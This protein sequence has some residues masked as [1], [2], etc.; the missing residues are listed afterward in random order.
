MALLRK[1]FIKEGKLR[2]GW[3]VTLYLIVY[4]TSMVLISA[5]LL[6]PYIH[7]LIMTKGAPPGG[8]GII[9]VEI[10][11]HTSRVRLE[12]VGEIDIGPAMLPMAMRIS[13]ELASLGTLLGITYLF[14]RFLDKK[15]FVSLGFERRRGWLRE[16]GLGL[17][18][19]FLL[20]GGIFLVHL[21]GGWI[22]VEGV[23]GGEALLTFLGFLV[24]LLPAAA[25]EEIAFRGYVFQ[26][27]KEG[28]GKVAAVLVSSLIFGLFHGLNPHI[29]P[30]ALFDLCLAG[31]LFA[32][33]CLVTGSLWLPIA[34]HFAWNLFEGP[35]FGFP[36][37]G[38]GMGGLLALKAGE[39]PWFLSGGPFGP[40][41][42]LVGIGANLAGLALL[43]LWA[44]SHSR[45]ASRRSI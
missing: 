7:Y 29:T 32:Y 31:V 24:F 4:P 19:G 23:A 9:E 44:R 34:L 11:L 33:A 3:R 1:A 39:A 14:R 20:M 27:I 10:D 42:G 37:S 26:N 28:W 30:L 36:V 43:W 40:E 12:G 5:L 38:L 21:A 35:V 22:K 16:I 25:Q 45:Q 17:G 8:P 41:G 6:A 18:L 13:L 2:P 15:S